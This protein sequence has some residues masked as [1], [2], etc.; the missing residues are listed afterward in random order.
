ML[1]ARD[2]EIAERKRAEGA[3]AVSESRLHALLESA[4]QGVVAVC[5]D[6]R[7]V[8]V[9]AKT[10]PKVMVDEIYLSV[11]NRMPTDTER[12]QGEK[13]LTTNGPNEGAQDLMWALINSPAFL[14][15]R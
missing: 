7:I 11:F 1:A 5:Q 9:N 3:L 15:N 14:F 10:E 13:Y 12:Q 2:S 8:L 6:G 4:S